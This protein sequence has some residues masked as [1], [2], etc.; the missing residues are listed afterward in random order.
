[1]RV[2]MLQATSMTKREMEDKGA[3]LAI[4]LRL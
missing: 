1:M 3:S 4:G 2:V